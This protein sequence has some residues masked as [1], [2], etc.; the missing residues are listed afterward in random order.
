MYD[1]EGVD[2]LLYL[3]GHEIVG[4][5]ECSY[6]PTGADNWMNPR[7]F[8]KR[9]MRPL[10]VDEIAV[11]PMYQG[12]GVGSFMLDQLQHLARTRGCTHLVL[13]VAEN[14]KAA[15][16]WYTKRNFFRLDAAIFLAQKIT[17]EPELL[18]PRPIKRRHPAPPKL[19]PAPSKSSPPPASKRA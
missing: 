4:Y 3:I 18:P 17:V 7:Y 5:T 2:Q 16:S 13:E 6:T 1:D 19:K 12:H 15:L 8:D 14:N 10:F 11:H 9:G